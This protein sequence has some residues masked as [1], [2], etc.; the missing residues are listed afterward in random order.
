MIMCD[1]E[2]Q[3]HNYSVPEIKSHDSID[4]IN[5]QMPETDSQKS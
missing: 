3:Q 1:L 5:Q 2:A 4:Q